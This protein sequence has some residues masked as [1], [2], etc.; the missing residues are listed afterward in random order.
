VI[1]EKTLRD[2]LWAVVAGWRRLFSIF[3]RINN[4]PENNDIGYLCSEGRSINSYKIL[5]M[6]H[7][8]NSISEAEFKCATRESLSCA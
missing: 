3:S 7:A 8:A 6:L 4:D 5:I 2:S 1:D